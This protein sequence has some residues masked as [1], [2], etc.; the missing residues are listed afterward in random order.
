MSADYL[1]AYLS[2]AD[3][4]VPMVEPL[5]PQQLGRRFGRQWV[6][7]ATD[8]ELRELCEQHP[9]IPKELDVEL[10]MHAEADLGSLREEPALKPGLRAG[11]WEILAQAGEGL[12]SN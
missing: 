9:R 7:R 11:F 12:D 8:D 10:I 3:A 4:A 1:N 5:E 2:A 6:S